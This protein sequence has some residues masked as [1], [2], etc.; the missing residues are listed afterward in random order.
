MEFPQMKIRSAQPFIILVLFLSI[1]AVAQEPPV[2]TPHQFFRMK[3][4]MQVFLKKKP[5]IPLT[6]MVLAVNIGSKD[7]SDSSEGWVHLME[8]L[9]MFSDT[10]FR[11]GQEYLKLWRQKGCYVNAHTDHDFMTM[12][13]SSPS[14]HSEYCLQLLK[15]KLFHL[16]PKSSDLLREKQI[17]TEEIRQ[18]EDDEFRHA[19]VRTLNLLFTNHVYGNP[20]YGN[21]SSLKTVRLERIRLAYEQYF[22]PSNCSLALVGDFLPED[23]K[24]TV[25]RLFGDIDPS[26]TAITT[27]SS[28]EPLKRNRK[29][30]IQ[31][32]IEQAV[33]AIGFR[34]PKFNHRDQFALTV[35]GH[36]LG[37][38]SNPLLGSA[39]RSRR[40]LTASFSTQYV[41]LKYAGAFLIYFRTEPRN[42]KLL[43]RQVIKFLNRINTIR[44][45]KADY[46]EKDQLRITDFLESARNEIRLNSETFKE[47][48]IHS[49][50][51]F[52]RFMLLRN[53]DESMNF[54]KEMESV[55]SADLRRVASDYIC[56]KPHTT[57]YILPRKKNDKK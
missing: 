21:A 29:E 14:A 8:H 48:G 42:V 15:E 23:M 47:I 25:I 26:S 1:L 7:E 20:I 56:G 32:D 53:P 28:P 51:S 31:M 24:E 5:G 17:I 16:R 27:M 9:L 45:T 13:S 57:V 55:S 49:A 35:L 33:L 38:G 39:L 41:K 18:I 6:N 36:I 34:A 2:E 12:E 54:Q 50:R 30:I 37:K 43:K 40:K 10:R 3:N 19:M 22:K 44:Y 4:G 52:A 46:L 11:S